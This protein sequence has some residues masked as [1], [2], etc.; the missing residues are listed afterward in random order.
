MQYFL[1]KNILD[2]FFANQCIVCQQISN[3]NLCSQCL[4]QINTKPNL[5]IKNNNT[6]QSIFSPTFN[7]VLN[8]NLQ[9]S[10][11]DSILTCTDFKHHIIKKSIHYLKYKN[12]PN[13]AQ[14]LG[15]IMLRTLSQNLRI[16]NNIVLCPIPLHI[17]RLK[18]RGYNQAFLLAKYL[19]SHLNFPIYT[20]LY[21]IKDTPHQMKI[22]DRKNRIENVS[23]AFEVKK[24]T[25]INGQHLI[26]IDDVTTTLST[27]QQAAKAMSKLGFNS[28]NALILAH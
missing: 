21:R 22:S 27:I 10:Y 15:S 13:L 18:F 6:S 12:L 16:K 25:N 23:N 7:T 26:I 19:N 1:N 5:W 28:I 3:V 14:P 24:N 2:I 20:D 4:L 17:N 11:I 9:N 8:R